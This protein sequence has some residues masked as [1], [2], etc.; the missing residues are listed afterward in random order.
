LLRAFAGREETVLITGATGSGKSRLGRWCHEHSTR[1]GEAF[2]VLDLIGVPEDLQMA[3]LFGWRRGAFTGAIK[4]TPGAIARAEKGTLFLD[5]I[6]KLSMR[7][8]AGLLRFIEERLYRMLGDDTSTTRRADVRLLVGTNADLKSAVRAGRFREDLYYR[9]NVLPVKL[10]A[11]DERLDELP[12]WASYMLNRCATESA[13]EPATFDA[14]ALAKLGSISWPGNLR[15]L[16]N[17][18]RRSYVL[19]LGSSE[20]TNGSSPSRVVRASHVERALFFDDD[21]EKNTVV[22]LLT[23]VAHAF[24]REASRR[25]GSEE[26]PLTLELADTFRS[27]VLGAA[28]QQL[29]NREEAF[30]LFGQHQLV[31][32]RNHQRTLKRELQRINDLMK[33]LG[34]ELDA[35]LAKL[36]VETP[37]DAGAK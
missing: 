13:G 37:D 22:E 18:V 29:N 20:S 24:V 31:K 1:K 35:D 32:S 14:D 6:D 19:M 28:V 30:F 17:I 27:M 16:D 9:I 4:D 36:S 5:E 23:R 26:A 2:E 25:Q 3:E 8:Q 12:K 21:S 34:G 11:L 33:T 15:Q 10:P 7:A